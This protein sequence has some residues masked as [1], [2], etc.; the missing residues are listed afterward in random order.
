MNMVLHEED[1]FKLSAFPVSGAYAWGWDSWIYH[2]H[3]EVG[4]WFTC[5]CVGSTA[6]GRCGAPIPEALHGLWKL[7]NWDNLQAHLGSF[8]RQQSRW[9]L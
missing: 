4:E 6:C 1:G 7:H 2:Y 8:R 3:E 5:G 9:R